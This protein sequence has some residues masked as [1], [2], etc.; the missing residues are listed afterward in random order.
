M[1]VVTAAG[2]AAGV[3]APWPGGS[4]GRW[5]HVKATQPCAE[6]QQH[7]TTHP[8]SCPL[9]VLAPLV[10]RFMALRTRLLDNDR[11]A[12]KRLDLAAEQLK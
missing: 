3:Q 5:V 4:S 8:A 12:K 9:Q 6:V 2:R 11:A 7:S 10:R 1:E